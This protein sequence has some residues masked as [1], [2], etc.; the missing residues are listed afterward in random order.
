MLVL[1]SVEIVFI[2][3]S[4]MVWMMMLQVSSEINLF[5]KVV[6]Q[7]VVEVGGCYNVWG[8]CYIMKM[9][10]ISKFQLVYIYVVQVMGLLESCMFRLFIMLQ[11]VMKQLVFRVQCSLG[12]V[13]LLF[14]NVN[15]MMLFEISFVF[16][17][18]VGFG[19]LLVSRVVFS[20]ISRGEDLCVIGQVWFSLLLW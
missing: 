1:C 10:G 5:V 17:S 19:I 3:V 18:V 12:N 16:S 15:V 9:V 20:V 4:V 7:V 2:G 13:I 11:V 14:L 8:L 6:V